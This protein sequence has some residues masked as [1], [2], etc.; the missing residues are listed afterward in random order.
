[1]A[2]TVVAES[3][4][5]FVVSLAMTL[6]EVANALYGSE[7]FTAKD[8]L[9]DADPKDLPPIVRH[10]I[11]TSGH[12]VMSMGWRLRQDGRLVAVGKKNG[13]VLWVAG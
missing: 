12:A 8:F 5:A 3:V 4:E 6:F 9:R 11:R 2:V 1:M 10:A 13:M 7:P